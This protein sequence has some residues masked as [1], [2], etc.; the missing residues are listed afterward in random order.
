MKL[1]IEFSWADVRQ[2]LKGGSKALAGAINWFMS[3][4]TDSSQVIALVEKDAESAFKD[5][6]DNFKS[7]LFPNVV[8]TSEEAECNYDCSHW[9]DSEI[10][11]C[12][13]CVHLVVKTLDNAT[14]DEK[15]Q[16]IL[17]D[18]LDALCEVNVCALKHYIK[19]L[20]SGRC[21]EWEKKN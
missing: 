14:D 4:P 5:I 8:F 6:L 19:H 11:F 21:G 10:D 16:M 15:K 2:L 12:A 1:S 9:F 20:Y 7:L 17:D 13:E 3:R 18:E